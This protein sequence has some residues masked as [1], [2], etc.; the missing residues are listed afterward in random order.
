MTDEMRSRP[1]DVTQYQ[2]LRGSSGSMRVIKTGEVDLVVTSPPY[3]PDD[4][5]PLLKQPLPEQNDFERVEKA[6]T[7]FALSTRSSFQEVKRVLKRGGAFVVQTK[8]IRYSQFL[9]PLIELHLD[10]ALNSGFRLISRLYWLSTPGSRARLP[11]FTQSL[12]RGDFR[13]LDTE[14]FL[15]FSHED[16]LQS[17]SRIE[18]IDKNQAFEL[19]QPLWRMPQNG[20]KRTHKYGSPRS[21]VHQFI[22]LYSEPGDLVLDPFVGFGTTMI[23]AKK[24]GRRAVGYDTDGQCVT[25]TEE[26]L[27]HVEIE[28]GGEDETE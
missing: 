10:M 9:V 19:I 23:E 3:F 8:D 25:I 2:V 18:S 6:I 4:I 12:R 17:G 27:D 15:V 21:V 26:N 14:V 1:S 28:P 11:K 5:E 20:G 7:E 24:L 16:G 22:E 13:V